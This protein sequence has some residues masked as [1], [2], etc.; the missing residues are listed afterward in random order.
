MC[1]VPASARNGWCKDC[2]RIL[3]SGWKIVSWTGK[4]EGAVTRDSVASTCWTSSSGRK[5]IA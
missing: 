4:L 2:G 5:F 3:K 1:W